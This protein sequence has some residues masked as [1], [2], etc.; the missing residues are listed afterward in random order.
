MEKIPQHIA[1]IMDG[2]GRWAKKRG[3]PRNVGHSQGSKTVRKICEAAWNFGVKYLTIYAFSTENW[4]RPQ[5]EIDALMKLLRG[6]L[7]DAEKQCAENNMR[8]RIIGD[9][10]VLPEDMITSIKHLE[11][12]SAV[13]T[14]LQ[15]QIAL[16]YGGKDEILRAVKKAAKKLANEGKNIEDMTTADISS[17]LDT[18]EIPDPDLIIRTS[19]EQRLSNFLMWQSAYSEFYFTDVLWP[20]FDKKDLEKAILYYGS[21]DRRFGGLSK[22]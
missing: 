4:S 12:V 21:R 10:S 9:I 17:S 18:A 19:G 7:K 1:I 2:N 22:N 6:F 16:N 13:N 8:V 5:E 3:L 20:D 11:E 15:F 14:G